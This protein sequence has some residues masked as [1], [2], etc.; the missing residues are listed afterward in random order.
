MIPELDVKTI[1]QSFQRIQ[2][3]KVDLFYLIDPFL[4]AEGVNFMQMCVLTGIEMGGIQ[5]INNV[6]RELSVSQ[7]NASTMCKKLE[8][9]GFLLRERNADDERVVTLSLTEKGH[10]FT[11][12]LYQLLEHYGNLAL[13]QFPEQITLAVQGFNAIAELL[14]KF[15]QQIKDAAAE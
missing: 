2:Q 7:G 6:C 4:K 13:A 5:Q 8:Q 12:H 9:D 10:A 11:C 14:Q 1:A 3:L 15:A